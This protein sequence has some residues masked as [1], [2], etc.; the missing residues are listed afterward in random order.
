VTGPVILLVGAEGPGAEAVAAARQA[1]EAVGGCTPVGP[2]DLRPADADAVLLDE[3]RA[4]DTLA[5]DLGLRASLRAARVLRPLAQRSPLRPERVDR[6]D[7]LVVA[8]RSGAA[9]DALAGLALQ[10]AARR[11][12]HLTWIG[13]DEWETPVERA[14]ADHEDVACERAIAGEAA[15]RLAATPAQLD[16][17][18]CDA[19]TGEALAGAA[20]ALTGT[21]HVLPAAHAGDGPWLCSPVR[22]HPVGAFLAAAMLLRHGF[23]LRGKAARIEQALDAALAAGLRTPDLATGAA[24]ERPANALVLTSHILSTMRSA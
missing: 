6:M 12:G 17:V 18:L 1:L 10:A 20:A 7:V 9:P 3:A 14:A 13:P 2:G 16:V 5:A 8:P 22:P 11:R 21:P 15:G 24:G 19:P 23:G 4:A